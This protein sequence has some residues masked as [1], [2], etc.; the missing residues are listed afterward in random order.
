VAVTQTTL[1]PMLTLDFTANILADMVLQ[2]PNITP[3]VKVIS[4]DGSN[5][6]LSVPTTELIPQ[7]TPV[8]FVAAQKTLYDL[9]ITACLT[10]G[11]ITADA[12]PGR[13]LRTPTGY[14]YG[15][16]QGGFYAFNLPLRVFNVT[17]NSANPG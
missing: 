1:S 3:D 2:Q 8:A 12:I 17:L 6:T 10:A 15:P 7:G 14:P 9:F 4:V 16:N 11:Y 13:S 5:V